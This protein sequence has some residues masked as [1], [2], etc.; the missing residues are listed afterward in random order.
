MRYIINGQQAFGK[1]VL[2]KM[3]ARGDEVVAVFCAPDKGG[4]AD[5]LKEFAIEKGLPVHQPASY[6][7]EEARDLVASYE[8]DLG[9]M[10]FVTLFVPE[11]ILYLPTHG[12][13][14]YHPSLLPLHR[15]PSSINWPIVQGATKTGLSIFWPDNGLDEGPILLQKECPIGPDDTLGSIYFNTL[16]PM[17][18]DAMLESIDLVKAGKAPR[19]DQDHSKSTYESWFKKDLAEID[20][21]KP[22]AEVYNLIRG[23]N[24][25]P[26]AWTTMA[27]K[28]L[29]V[30]DSARV[31]E[32][33][34]EA[35]GTV[36]DVT[37][38]GFRVAAEGGQI[39]VKRVRP[40]G[41]D[42]IAAG[43][44]KIDKGTKLGG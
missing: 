8:P 11:E 21:S 24:P 22:A 27:G 40:E 35:P 17:G 36:T 16:F 18:V 42:K 28:K 10:A 3:L 14:Q 41:G 44:L 23:T 13:I 4:R 6:K 29:D 39:L 9:V 2:E 5:P 26:G 30:F 32:A 37:G 34:A 15:G 1:A 33:A 25:A 38:E 7:T 43:E 20:W 12:T 31:D 19:V